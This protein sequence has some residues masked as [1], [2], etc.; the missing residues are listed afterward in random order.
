MVYDQNYHNCSTLVSQKKSTAFQS[1]A[2]FVKLHLKWM[3]FFR[4]AGLLNKKLRFDENYGVN[5]SVNK[6][7]VLLFYLSDG[8]NSQLRAWRA[9]L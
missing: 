5:I 9:C 6:V 2:V 8:L 4:P 7:E 3:N 1:L